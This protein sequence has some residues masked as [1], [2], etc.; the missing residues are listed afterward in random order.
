MPPNQP[1]YSNTLYIVMVEDYHQF[2][3]DY[4]NK[5][6]NYLRYKSGNSEV[7]HDIMQESFTR[8]FKF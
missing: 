6:F 8:H 1:G 4:K 7:A 3:A 2:Y 5:L